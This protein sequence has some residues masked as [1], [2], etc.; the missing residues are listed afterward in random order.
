MDQLVLCSFQSLFFHQ[1]FLIK[2]LS[3]SQSGIFDLDVH[4]LFQPRQSDHIARKVGDLDRFSHIQHEDL[5]TF[6]TCSRL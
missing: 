2:L 4:A 5:P 1:K 3:R 6:C